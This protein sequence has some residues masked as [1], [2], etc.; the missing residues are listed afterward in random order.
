M[1]FYDFFATSR[2]YSAHDYKTYATWPL[3]LKEE[4]SKVSIWPY[5]PGSLKLS[6]T[7]ECGQQNTG[8]TLLLRN[9]CPRVFL[10]FIRHLGNNETNS[11]VPPRKL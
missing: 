8:I 11:S 10:F 3:A 7:I 6:V 9:L 5:N 1:L 4:Q 2:F